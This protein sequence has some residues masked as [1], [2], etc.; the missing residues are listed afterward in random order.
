[1]KEPK[2]PKLNYVIKKAIA[3]TVHL[4]ALAVF[5]AGIS[6]LY[7]NDNFKKGISWLNSEAYEDSQAFVSIIDNDI[8]E[9]YD[10]I[11][12]QNI[13][14][15]DDSLDYSY[16]MFSINEGP[17]SDRDYTVRD[18]INYAKTHGFA[19]DEYYSI[20]G[21]TEPTIN[22]ENPVS[23]VLV[24]YRTYVGDDSISE[25]GD[26]YMTMTRLITESLDCIS[27]YYK[28]YKKFTVNAS[29]LKYKII[30]DSSEYTNEP[31]LTNP[32]SG[33]GKYAVYDSKTHSI[34]TDLEYNP[35]NISEK[36]DIT[37]DDDDNAYTSIIAIDTTYSAK[38]DLYYGHLN[39]KH[40][41]NL[42]FI[43]LLSTSASLIV[44]LISFIC[45][46]YMSGKSY[47]G[48]PNRFTLYIDSISAEL[49]IILCCICIMLFLF[50]N[51]R[52]GSDLMH[53]FV[54]I[55]HWGFAVKM[56]ACIF[57]Y[58]CCL[59]FLFVLIRQY[60][61]GILWEH[62][63]LKRL[64]AE[65]TVYEVKHGFTTTLI[66]KYIL[67]VFINILL[68]IIT[69]VLILSEHTLIFRFVIVLLI[70]GIILFDFITFH[71]LYKSELQRDAMSEA[72][73][74]ISCGE[75]S[76]QLPLDKFS[77][78]NSDVAAT[79]NNI[80]EGLDKALAQQVKSERMKADLITNVS[81]DIKTPLTS[82]I[83]YIDL[84]KREHPTDPKLCEY[85][86]V[87]DNKSQHLKTLTEDLVEAS[88]ASSGNMQLNMVP[89]NF[90]ELINQANGE[91][92]ERFTQRN[93]S[94]VASLPSKPVI[95]MA[96]GNHL[97][98]VLENIYSN[99]CK[100]A[101][102]NSRV[103]I[104]MS[105]DKEGRSATLVAKNVSSRPLNISPDELT[106]RFVR[107]DVS[108]TTE[109]SGLGLSIAKSLTELQGGSFKLDID[110]DLFKIAISFNIKA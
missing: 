97:W 98:R 22:T 41:R 107:G 6:L 32:P 76:Y 63:S 67:F 37:D 72:L 29:N 94:L 26:A 34:I 30:D 25:P 68:F 85:L 106:E 74:K 65:L 96:D 93:L 44:M 24:N 84:M 50:V 79:I 11:K 18:V 17:S 39:Y 75:T 2:N 61:A 51:E 105:V 108:R 78:K 4:I 109:G 33:Y 88:K 54:P 102:E 53:I 90:V 91:F 52:A 15:S 71:L 92:E 100:Y 95:I 27:K 110:G 103:Y 70:L 38:D 48:D 58:L 80:S 8:R 66:I 89:I 82:I 49:T 35:T 73:K 62:S 5:V 36:N 16:V 47:K 14:E 45:L 86:E 42:Y 59:F 23:L 31:S 69:A 101:A 56:S 46:V 28:G 57:I 77:G 83:N 21:Q 20:T 81:H 60:K 40:Q 7:C 19:L 13:L 99:I 3:V 10:Y 12:Y 1:M 87:L 55:D 43:G 9:L 64:R 104:N